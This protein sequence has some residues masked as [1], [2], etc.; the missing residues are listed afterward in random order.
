[1]KI[2]IVQADVVYK[3]KKENISKL[4]SMLANAE[5]VGDLTLLPEMFSTGY[6]FSKPSE[7]HNL[8]EDYSNSET[9]DA[10]RLL[11]KEYDTTFVAGIAEQ[12]DGKYYNSV[13]VISESGLLHRYRKISQNPI[14]QKYFSR[15]ES[16]LSFK[17]KGL[18][19]GIAICFD[20]WFPE[21]IRAYTKE[22]I[23]VLLHPAN[24][25]GQQSLHFSKLRA[26]ENSFYVVTCNRV[27]KDVTKELTGQYCGS[28]CVFNPAGEL[29]EQFGT[30]SSVQTIEITNSKPAPQLIG[31]SLNDE[32]ETIKEII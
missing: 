15:G 28:S 21:I 22:N 17:H 18:V 10:I 12:H 3:N 4:S 30:A 29:V 31:I 16:T 25:G 24:F 13:A 5:E 14:D 20:I 23:D 19:F 27:G 32:I 26:L 8:S 9:I 11:A 2:T 7:I 6:I 1:M